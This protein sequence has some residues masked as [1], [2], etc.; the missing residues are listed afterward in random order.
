M[1]I[2]RSC[3]ISKSKTLLSFNQKNAQAFAKSLYSEDKKGKVT[4]TPLCDATLKDSKPKSH[5]KPLHCV[6]GEAYLAFIGTSNKL[7]ALIKSNGTYESK[8]SAK[9]GN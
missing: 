6:M 1:T 3:S 7:D 8:F 5:K 2:N 9:S 4:F